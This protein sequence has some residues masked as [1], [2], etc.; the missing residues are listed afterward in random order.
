[1]Q[2]NKI[3]NASEQLRFIKGG[4]SVFTIKNNE[5]DNRYTFKVKKHKEKELWF[6]SVL[7]GGDNTNS[8]SYIGTIFDDGFKL[9]KK[10]NFKEDSVCYKAFSWLYKVL[11]SGKELPEKVEF[12]HEGKCGR[13]G[14]KLTVPES[15]ETGFGPECASKL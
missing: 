1:M 6:V 3:N 15:I 13:C 5:T 4:N 9:T 7:T 14:R 11:N 2:A 12:W 8:Y 10:S